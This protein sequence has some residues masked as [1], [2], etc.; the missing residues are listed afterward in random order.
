MRMRSLSCT[1][2]EARRES[3]AG[4][5]C[6]YA[7]LI[8]M[9]QVLG[10]HPTV[11]LNQRIFRGSWTYSSGRKQL[12]HYAPPQ[13][14]RKLWTE[15]AMDHALRATSE[16]MSVREA[17]SQYGVPKSTLHD[18]VSG[19][20]Q[21][22]AVPG[23]HRYLDV[24]EEEEVVRW[25][26]GCA[27]IGYAKSVREVRSIVGAIVA[28]KNNLENFVVSHGWWDRFRA[29]HPHLTLR[30]GESLAYHRAVS[31]NRFVI[32]KYFDLLEE[33]LVSNNLCFAPHLIFNADETGLPLQHRPG[34]RVAVRGQK[35]VHVVNSG[36]KAHISVLACVSAS[37]YAIPPMVIFPR[38]TLTP[39]LT[40]QEVPGTIYGLSA[41]GWM[42]RELFQEWFHRHFLQ[43]VPSSRPLL[44]VL[45]GHSSHYSL[46]FIR[47][48]T[49]EGVIV[50]CLPPHTTHITQPLD[51]SAF[52]SLK[53]Y[54]DSECDKF[55]SANPGRL[56]T[57]Y[58]F[59]SLF[60]L[61][62]SR[63]MTPQT[64]V[65][66]FKATGVFP[67]NRRAIHVP[68]YDALTNT[69][70]AVV[71]RRG[72]IKY[73]PFLSKSHQRA[74]GASDRRGPLSRE[75]CYSPTAND[76]S[77][78]MNDPI[79]PDYDEQDFEESLIGS[80]SSPQRNVETHEGPTTKTTMGRAYYGTE[81][82]DDGS[83]ET[84]IQETYSPKSTR[85]IVLWVMKVLQSH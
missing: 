62:W 9:F 76:V 58:Q 52:H 74:Q 60:S 81:S 21:P 35:H 2:L 10:G 46:E 1:W 64:I 13:N 31:T 66:G 56:I 16:G 83:S 85:K 78:D 70:T 49:L 68:G 61:A 19:R 24:E 33:V 57:I 65:S 23:A 80:P 12:P 75:L 30:T 44:L 14:R 20:V 82:E 37:G 72:G 71:A 42:D 55:M 47:E 27:S 7:H 67:L 32:D 41:S 4:N 18:R 25:L 51:V 28:A 69:P 40:T 6:I 53:T 29:R 73:M 17:A 36:N 50:F 79:W 8:D 22:G 48:A 84:D 5:D 43:H 3:A 38:K 15:E 26:E 39:H 59:S 77:A 54:W 11:P 45:D 34:K 63:A